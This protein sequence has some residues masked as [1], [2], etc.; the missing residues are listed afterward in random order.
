MLGEEQCDALTQVEGDQI[1]GVPGIASHS[2]VVNLGL[3]NIVVWNFVVVDDS[4]VSLSTMNLEVACSD[5]PV[6]K[7]AQAQCERWI[8]E[9]QN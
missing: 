6:G 7:I 9:G 3:W 8:E 5:L 2:L 1:H 4:L